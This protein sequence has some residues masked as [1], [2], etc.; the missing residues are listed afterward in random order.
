MGVKRIIG[1]ILD[2]V[3]AVALEILPEEAE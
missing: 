3:K 2:H 1:E